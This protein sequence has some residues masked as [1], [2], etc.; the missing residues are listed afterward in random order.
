MTWISESEPVCWYTV[1]DKCNTRNKAKLLAMGEGLEDS[2]YIDLRVRKV[3]GRIIPGDEFYFEGA[4]M[5]LCDEDDDGA[6]PLWEVRDIVLQ[7]ER[8][9]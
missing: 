4:Y 2:E 6:F 8:G 3:Y 7:E 1:T 5:Q 9:W